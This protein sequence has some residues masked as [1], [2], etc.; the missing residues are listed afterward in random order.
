MKRKDTTVVIRASAGTGKTYQLTNRYLS[1]IKDGV[2]PEHILTVTFTRLAA[3]EILERVLLRLAEAAVDLKK[4]EALAKELNDGAFTR[5]RCLNLLQELTSNLHRMRI[6]TLDAYFAQLARSF[7]L[8]IGLP[9]NWSILEEVQDQR[10]R[11]EA[12]QQTIAD[13]G[14]R[15]I[16]RLVRVLF[17]GEAK[18]N[19]S[20]LLFDTI[21]TLYSVLLETDPPAWKRFPDLKP[22]DRDGIRE[23][24]EVLDATSP[25]E[26][27]TAARL[28]A[29]NVEAAQL[30]NW[31]Q[32]IS[33]GIAAHLLKGKTS[34][35][36]K[37][38]SAELQAAYHAVIDHARAV[39][40][41]QLKHQ[42]EATFEILQR[43]DV[44]YR[45]LKLR[46]RGIRFEDVTHTLM[47]LAKSTNP[48]EQNF[49]LDTEISHLLLDEFQDTSLRQWQIIRP[50]AERITGGHKMLFETAWSSFFC[51]GD[52]KQ[53]IYG[54]RGGRSEIFDALE[55]HL[56][57]IND[58]QLNVSYRS[59]PAIIEVVNRVFKQIKNHTH[60]ESVEEVV[61]HWADSFP[62][63][64]TALEDAKGFVQLET[65]P[66]PDWHEDWIPAH[67]QQEATFEF[68][69][70][71]VKDL[72]ELMPDRTI[73]ILVRRNSAVARLIYELRK[74]GVKAS[75]E[76]GG[77]PLT[78]SAA[79]QVIL[80]LLRLADHPDD[81]IA[82]FHLAT[83]PIA[84]QFGVNAENYSEKVAELS[85]SIRRQLMD[86]GYGATLSGWAEQLKPFSNA[87]DRRRLQQLVELGFR[88]ENIA[89]IRTTDFLLY[90][91]SERI[92]DPLIS[93]V[94]VMTVH[95]SKGLEF[96]VVVLPELESEI[97]AYTHAVVWDSPDPT[98]SIDRVCIYRNQKIQAVLPPDMQQMFQSAKNREAVESLCLLYVA[99][100]RAAH[101]M[102]MILP[103]ATK[104]TRSQPRTFAGLL[105]VALAPEEKLE[106]ESV[107]FQ[108]GDEEWFLSEKKSARA[109]N[110]RISLTAEI[111]LASAKSSTRFDFKSPSG[112][113]GG[114]QVAASQLLQLSNRQALERGTVIH[115]LFEQV[116]WINQI[117][118]DREL[119]RVANRVSDGHVAAHSQDAQSQVSEFRRML[120][121][122]QTV[123]VLTPEYYLEPFDENVIEA[124][125]DE[126]NAGHARLEVHNERSFVV[127]DSNSMLSGTIDR[128]VLIFNDQQLM[129][130]DI[131][132][133]KT[134]R[135]DF[136]NPLEIE[137]R[138][139]HYQP[140]IEAYR[141]AVASI[142]QL[143]LER[144]CGRLLFVGGGVVYGFSPKTAPSP[145]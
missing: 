1:L 15:T 88:F 40:L 51:V 136:E 115:A 98:E 87:R 10:L 126:F 59:A 117:P 56:E 102:Y 144:I 107:L 57:G 114:N 132:D 73:G 54:W 78:D 5:E 2:R 45:A 49:R 6:E 74:L 27:K 100:T 42:T 95:Q 130:A 125:P 39:L 111:Q 93:N 44:H 3:G 63:H 123:K 118:T 143:D 97:D 138:A 38:F 89:S 71:K 135:L 70:Q 121:R 34:Y 96:D 140:Q 127:P 99:M 81:Q 43:F 105:Q 21:N 92:A 110:E 72:S 48:E 82:A 23:A 106:P 76:R 9:P 131:V 36:K 11:W 58:H 75:E 141:R 47:E 50:L 122:E 91:E 29:E 79:V 4:C 52:V 80:S 13:D 64:Q 104:G 30:H 24:I 119:L 77:N 28:K 112:L 103:P 41:N 108:Y 20:Y 53:A 113:E 26:H 67:V 134:D 22:L 16:S 68:A 66:Q 62:E 120:D 25:P 33:K 60:L 133:F 116:T 128:L 69:A 94:R 55:K 35:Y 19:V 7:S 129:A 18:R 32:F 17:Q 46:N 142:F 145:V 65:A 8:E 86:S 84:D 139:K 61:H 85:S 90:V 14:D 37:E 109:D 12:L 137:K 101:A 83:S 124:I 31:E